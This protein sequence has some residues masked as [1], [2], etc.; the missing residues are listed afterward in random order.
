MK[1][2]DGAVLTC[3]AGDCSFNCDL[4][5]CAPE[6]MVGDEHPMCDSFT[7]D[8]ATPVKRSPYVQQCM[9]GDCHFNKQ[10]TCTAAGITLM[11]HADHADCATYR[12]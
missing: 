3:L 11:Q 9:V 6:V 4:M 8:A 7:T 1:F 10:R 5:C 12:A 2:K